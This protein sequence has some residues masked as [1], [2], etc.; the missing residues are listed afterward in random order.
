MLGGMLVLGLDGY[1]K[2]WVVARIV[3]GR[4]AGL[5]TAASLVEALEAHPEAVTVAV[6]I[7]IGL[8]EG[9]GPRP[10]DVEARDCLGRRAATVF[11]TPPRPVIEAGTHAEA[12]R[13]ARE[14]G[15]GAPSAQT[16]ALRRKILEVAPIAA[17]DDRIIE[18]HPEVA[19]R[20]LRGASL[21][22]PKRS[23]AGLAERIAILE[24][25]DLRPPAD[26]GAAKRAAAD[27]VLD[28]VVTAWV[29]WAHAKGEARFFPKEAPA[30]RHERI[31]YAPGPH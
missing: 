4:L 20:M 11:P 5:E 25:V 18:A 19:F 1:P 21:E 2:G 12:I 26:V 6:D 28:A 29:A 10:A 9:P 24:R 3:D 17:K 23:W 8:P 15:C 27:D 14:L 7:P 30:S 22:A 31:W 13:V 16:Y